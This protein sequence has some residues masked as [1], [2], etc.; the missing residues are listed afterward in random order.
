[1]SS[2]LD[3]DMPQ[4]NQENG[5]NIKKKAKVQEWH[6]SIHKFCLQENSKKGSDEIAG[7]SMEGKKFV[8]QGGRKPLQIK[9]TL[10]GLHL[11][12]YQPHLSIFESF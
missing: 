12:Q 11:I 8:H 1:M 4:I 3:Q 5:A 9:M 10:F 6:D 2:T 7:W